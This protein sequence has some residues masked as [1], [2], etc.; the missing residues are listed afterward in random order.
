MAPEKSRSGGLRTRRIIAV[1]IAGALALLGVFIGGRLS[2]PD[3]ATPGTDSAEAGFARDMQVH[4]QQAVVMSMMTRDE[5]DDPTVRRLAYDIALGQSQGAGQL[6]GYLVDWGLPQASPE[7]TMSW[8][9]LPALD[10]SDSGHQHGA[11][12]GP[13]P[14]GQM[15]GYATDAQ[16]TRL[17]TLRGVPAERYFLTLMIA[18]HRGGIGMAQSLL[19]R[20]TY[21]P[22][23]SFARSLVSVQSS[24]ITNM[25]S[26]LAAL[27]KS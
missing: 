20:S 9:S 12:S 21:G 27:P 25:Q 19:Q 18:H 11:A 24:E 6:Y 22:V 14:G 8:M 15:P 23:V 26:M 1:A 5:T 4:H 17:G 3:F 16:L 13:T 2:A 7:P 10:G